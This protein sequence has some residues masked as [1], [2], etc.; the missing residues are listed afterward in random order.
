MKRL[1]S[2]LCCALLFGATAVFASN[3]T[4]TVGNPPSEPPQNAPD[5]CADCPP[6]AQIEGEPDCGLNYIDNFNGG[7]N[8]TPPVFSVVSCNT[9]CGRMG[10]FLNGGLNYRDTDWYRITVGPGNFQYSGIGTAIFRTFVLT[11]VCPTVSLGTSAAPACVPTVPLNFVGP[12]TVVLFAGIDGFGPAFPCTS[13]YVMSISGPGI[14][15]CEV[16]AVEEG[17]WGGIKANY[18]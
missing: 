9:I 1:A 17:T 6:N 18:R 7:C 10:G 11:N 15:A 13:Q 14:P 12:G 5:G 2:L 3:D 8:S 16:T 4:G